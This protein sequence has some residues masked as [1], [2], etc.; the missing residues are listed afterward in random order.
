VKGVG[1]WSH[2]V[3]ILEKESNMRASTHKLV[4]LEAS[5]SKVVGNLNLQLT[6]K[7]PVC[8]FFRVY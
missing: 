1:P 4:F 8:E 2:P 3:V 7:G 6:S 5:E